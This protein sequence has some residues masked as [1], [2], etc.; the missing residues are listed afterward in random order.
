[1]NEAIFAGEEPK[2]G[3]YLSDYI[4]K[5]IIANKLDTEQIKAL[6]SMFSL[7]YRYF[8]TDRYNKQ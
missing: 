2:E 1:M 4:G 5:T 8:V 7:D 3:E 6:C